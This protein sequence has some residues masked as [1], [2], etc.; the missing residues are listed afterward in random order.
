MPGL[1]EGC[2]VVSVEVGDR[3]RGLLEEGGGA[4]GRGVRSRRL[5][6]ISN[7]RPWQLSRFSSL[8]NV[9]RAWNN[10]GHFGVPIRVV[11]ITWSVPS[12]VDL[13]A[14]L[15]ARDKFCLSERGFRQ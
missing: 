4:Y 6:F 2:G 13:L 14:R 5:L 8:M 15:L 1:G 3:F 7:P 10:H 12:V 9:L 11:M